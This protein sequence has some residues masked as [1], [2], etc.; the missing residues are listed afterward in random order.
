MTKTIKST[1][2]INKLKI[3]GTKGDSIEMST[4]HPDSGYEFFELLEIKV[5]LDTWLVVKNE[6]K[7]EVKNGG[8]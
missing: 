4:Y 5:L 1:E 2:S 3:D 8:I 6:V 7:N